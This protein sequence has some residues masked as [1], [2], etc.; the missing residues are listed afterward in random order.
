LYFEVCKKCRFVAGFFC[1]FAYNSLIINTIHFS[2]SL[3]VTLWLLKGMMAFAGWVCLS[4]PLIYLILLI[5]MKWIDMLVRCDHIW[6]IVY[7]WFCRFV[8][9]CFMCFDG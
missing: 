5:H 8:A 3:R 4:E 7:F 2:G 1:V 6:F 9:G